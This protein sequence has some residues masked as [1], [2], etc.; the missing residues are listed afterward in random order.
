MCLR[1]QPQYIV[2]PDAEMSEDWDE[3]EDGEWERPEIKNPDYKGE[4]KQKMM[5]NPEYKGK[6]EAP[7]IKNP[8]Y[9]D[10]SGD[11]LYRYT[12]LKY[13]GFELWQVKAGSIFDNILVTDDVEYAKEFAQSTWGAMKD[14]EKKL[15]E[16]T[17]AAE[18]E[19]A[20]KRFEEEQAKA[21]EEAEEEDVEED[22]EEHDEL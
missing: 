11:E 4:W 19:E 21:E 9:V 14:V 8:E 5:D 7:M 6:W 18:E 15:F 20:K 12:D 16:D 1:L 13:V 2:D 22:G 10:G 3:E 17:K